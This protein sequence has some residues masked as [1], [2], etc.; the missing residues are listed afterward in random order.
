M[1][2]LP[3]VYQPRPT[4]VRRNAAGIRF[5]LRGFATGDEKSA[6]RFHK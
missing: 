3:L 2:G 5:Q 4:L 6:H 1:T